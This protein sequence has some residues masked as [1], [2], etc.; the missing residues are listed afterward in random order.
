MTKRRSKAKTKREAKKLLTRIVSFVVVIAVAFLLYQFGLLDTV[1]E[2]LG[3]IQPEIPSVDLASLPEFDERFPYV[4]INGDVPMFK[5]EDLT[6]ESYETYGNLDSLGRCT[7]TIACIGIDLMPS[8]DREDINNVTPSGWVQAK[9]DGKYLYNRCHLIG[10]Q[11]TGENDN[12]RNLI[13]GTRFMNVDGMLPFEKKVAA[14]IK[15][16]ENHVMYRATP[17][18]EGSNLVAKGVLME[19]YSVEDEGDGI[20]FCIFVYNNQPGIVIDY[21]TGES[22]KAE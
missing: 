18:Y 11:L 13:T 3:L 16:T 15:E 1:L 17:I 10:F 7:V 4:K 9:Y 19:A 22:S 2:E 6:T 21:A 12:E 14:Y 20:C 8:E 5:A